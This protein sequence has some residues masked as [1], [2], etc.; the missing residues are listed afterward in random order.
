MIIYQP[1]YIVTVDPR[2]AYTEIRA[3]TDN[4]KFVPKDGERVVAFT[5][6]V[7]IK[8]NRAFLRPYTCVEQIKSFMGITSPWILTPKQL[9]REVVKCQKY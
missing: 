2:V 5:R 6:L 3:Y 8:K 9:Y 4:F 7:A 1:G